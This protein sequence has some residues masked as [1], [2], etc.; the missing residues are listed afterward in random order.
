MKDLKSVKTDV[1]GR[2]SWIDTQKNFRQFFFLSKRLGYVLIVFAMPQIVFGASL[3]RIGVGRSFWSKR[4]SGTY[5]LDLDTQK[6]FRQK[7]FFLKL[8][9]LC[10][11]RVCHGL[12]SIPSELEPNRSRAMLTVGAKRGADRPRQENFLGYPFWAITFFLLYGFCQTRRQRTECDESFR[13]VP[14]ASLQ[15]AQKK[16][17]FFRFW[18]V[19]YGRY[20]V[21]YGPRRGFSLITF[22]P[23]VRLSPNFTCRLNFSLRFF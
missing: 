1:W 23:V 5:V 4:M 16:I 3:G 7:I 21:M 17:R 6:I 22:Y 8:T 20:L 10:L 12:N 18:L 14:V 9:G 15:D 11:S 2:T 19:N 13:M